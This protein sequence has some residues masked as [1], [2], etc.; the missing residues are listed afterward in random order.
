M[1]VPAGR[2][3]NPRPE[4]AGQDSWEPPSWILRGLQ[5]YLL[6]HFAQ[7]KPPCPSPGALSQNPPA[8]PHLS[9][10]HSPALPGQAIQMRHSNRCLSPSTEL[11]VGKPTSARWGW[12][13]NWTGEQVWAVGPMGGWAEDAWLRLHILTL[14]SLIPLT[15]PPKPAPTVPPPESWAAPPPLLTPARVPAS[16]TWP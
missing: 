13:E 2:R 1:G 6:E 11:S 4:G 12:M 7:I 5:V 9:T 15:P 14:P 8:F 16:H 10:P 3:G